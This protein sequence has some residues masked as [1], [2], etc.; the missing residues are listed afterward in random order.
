MK[1]RKAGSENEPARSNSVNDSQTAD[2]NQTIQQIASKFGVTIPNG[3]LQTV[4]NYL[5]QKIKEN[6][7]KLMEEERPKII[8]GLKNAIAEMLDKAQKIGVIPQQTPNITPQE[9]PQ[10]TPNP[11]PQTQIDP[12]LI[13]LMGQFLGGGGSTDLKKLAETIA[14]ARAIADALNK[15][16]M[17]DMLAQK[18]FTRWLAKQG[19][20]TEKELKA[21]E[22]ETE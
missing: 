22:A 12:S 5:D 1:K 4:N 18:A 2:Q 8:Q 9:T 14:T 21:A 20:I 3:I 16:S 11:T 13:T 15:P 7:Q 17:M 10:Q 19:L 6:F